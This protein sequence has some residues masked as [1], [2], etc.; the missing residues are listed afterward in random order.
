MLR[1]NEENISSKRMRWVY[2]PMMF[3]D[4]QVYL[5]LIVYRGEEYPEWATAKIIINSRHSIYSTKPKMY[6]LRWIDAHRLN[7]RGTPHRG[8]QLASTSLTYLMKEAEFVTYNSFVK[9]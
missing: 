4:D 7:F 2:S 8:E 3:S 9:E 1:H 5:V 6:K